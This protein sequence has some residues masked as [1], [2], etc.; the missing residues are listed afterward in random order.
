L[1]TLLVHLF[2]FIR[3]SFVVDSTV[4]V[5]LVTTVSVWFTF[6]DWFYVGSGSVVR[7]VWS[8]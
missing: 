8:V 3:C 1:F 4:W 2:V 5:W 7:V 6:V